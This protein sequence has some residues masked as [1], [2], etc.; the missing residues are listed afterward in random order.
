MQVEY[1][2]R[3]GRGTRVILSFLRDDNGPTRPVVLI[4]GP[5]SVV[6][7][8]EVIKESYPLSTADDVLA[9]AR[10]ALLHDADPSEWMRVALSL[11]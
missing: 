3:R 7:G 4:M 5:S 8:Y 10:T 2:A 11:L 6:P 1:E 9:E